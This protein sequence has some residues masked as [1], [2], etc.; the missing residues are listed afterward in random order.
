MKRKPSLFWEGRGF[1]SSPS[2]EEEYEQPAFPLVVLL[3]HG[4]LIDGRMLNMSSTNELIRQG[5]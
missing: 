4:N 3:H 2:L 5:S 1:P